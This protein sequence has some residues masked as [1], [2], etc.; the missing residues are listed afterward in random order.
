MI[1][2]WQWELLTS[3]PLDVRKGRSHEE[4][5][6][7]YAVLATYSHHPSVMTIPHTIESP[8][9]GSREPN[10]LRSILEWKHLGAVHPPRRRPGQP[11]DADEYVAH[12]Y[13]RFARSTGDFPFQLVVAVD[14]VDGVAECGHV[15]GDDEV[16]TAADD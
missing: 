3:L 16:Q 4:G 2:G 12:G 14:A 5:E 1:E 9:S 7:N 15:C 11:I 6:R 10:T 8:I 13:H